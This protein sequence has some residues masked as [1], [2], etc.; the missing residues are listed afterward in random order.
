VPNKL[1]KFAADHGFKLALPDGGLALEILLNVIDNLFNKESGHERVT[2]MFELFKEEFRHV[3]KTKASHE[4]VQRAAQLAIWYD[5]RE[6]DD[7][8]RARYVKLIG[9]S[10]RSEEQIRDVAS[11]VQTIEQLNERDLCV[12]RVINSVMNKDGDWQRQPLPGSQGVW[13]VHPNTFIQR[14][15]ELS[16]QVA[17]ALDQDGANAVVNREEGYGI[18]NRLQGFGLTH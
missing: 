1:A 6:R 7:A 9:N 17:L 2:A 16:M 3:E 11:F 10:L 15:E 13:K 5:H 12:L 18:C 14:A 8:K 4:D